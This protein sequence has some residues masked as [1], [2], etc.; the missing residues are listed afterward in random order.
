MQTFNLDLHVPA[1]WLGELELGRAEEL[2]GRRLGCGR[3]FQGKTPG[4]GHA[5]RHPHL[6]TGDLPVEASWTST[7]ISTG[8]ARKGVGAVKTAI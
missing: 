4:L 1:S 8:P 6:V 5:D 2:V 7:L 3:I